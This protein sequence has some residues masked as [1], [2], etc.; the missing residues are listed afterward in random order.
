MPGSTVVVK[1]LPSPE[2]DYEAASEGTHA[3]CTPLICAVYIVASLQQERAYMYPCPS[4]KQ[5]DL[6]PTLQPIQIRDIA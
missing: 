3:Q 2:T 6:E 1:E 4:L 5:I